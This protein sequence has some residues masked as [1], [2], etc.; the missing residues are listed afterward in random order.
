MLTDY[1][2]RS[3]AAM[4]SLQSDSLERV[5]SK[6]ELRTTLI[7]NHDVSLKAALTKATTVSRGDNVGVSYNF[8]ISYT[9]MSILNFKICMFSVI[10]AVVNIHRLRVLLLEAREMGMTSGDYVF[11]FFKSYSPLLT[12]IWYVDGD[13]NNDVSSPLLKNSSIGY[14]WYFFFLSNETLKH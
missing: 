10:I 5:F 8:D 11:L 4:V 13:Q 7:V 12:D 14:S 1:Y 2:V 9:F 3:G 6:S